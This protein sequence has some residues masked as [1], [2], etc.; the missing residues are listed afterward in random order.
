[1]HS[2]TAADRVHLLMANTLLSGSGPPAGQCSCITAKTAQER[3]EER[4]KDLK[5]STWPLNSPDLKPT[6]HAL[7]EP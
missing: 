5:V 3:P 6:E 4:D 7:D 2:N 1:M